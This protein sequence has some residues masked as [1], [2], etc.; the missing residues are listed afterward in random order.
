MNHG[1]PV[2]CLEITKICVISPNMEYTLETRK[3]NLKRPNPGYRRPYKTETEIRRPYKT[4]TEI[5]TTLQ[6]RNRDN[7]D[8]TRQKPR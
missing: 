8:H 2:V 1:V 3:L 4:E 7:D 5:M 6:D